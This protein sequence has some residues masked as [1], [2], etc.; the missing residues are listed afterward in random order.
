MARLVKEEYEYF[1]L[2]STSHGIY[3]Y[4]LWG[5]RP[6]FIGI[7]NI[8]MEHLDYHVTYDLYV[9]AKAL[10]AK[11]AKIAVINA[12]DEMSFGKLKRILSS[13]PAKVVTYSQQDTIPASVLKTIKE[14]FKAEYNQMNARLVYALSKLIDIEDRDYNLGLKAFKGVAG[15][16]QMLERKNGIQVVIDFAHTPNALEEVLNYLREKKDGG[17]LIAVFGCAGLRDRKKRPAMGRIGA[18]L[19]DVSIFTSEDPRT[20]DPWLIIR[21]MKQNL[22]TYYGKVLSIVDREAAITFAITRV[23]KSGDIVGIFG[24]GHETSMCYGTIEK[25]W[26]DEKV[27]RTALQMRKS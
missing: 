1:I 6:L 26:S 12:D 3:Q 4:R 14:T 20:E 8:T 11:K 17:K 21:Q 16:L 24:K 18:E 9:Q 19:A 7:T 15:R 25:P 22:N 2:E 13:S 10:L 5:I 27:A 23:A